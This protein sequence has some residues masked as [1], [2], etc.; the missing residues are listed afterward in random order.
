M[1]LLF[2]TEPL[3]CFIALVA[4][5]LTILFNYTHSNYRGYDSLQF[6]RF[7]G[8]GCFR[9]PLLICILPIISFVSSVTVERCCFVELSHVFCNRR[10]D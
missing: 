8:L 9:I 6:P 10:N 5:L 7:M 4:I 2:T 3:F 1:N